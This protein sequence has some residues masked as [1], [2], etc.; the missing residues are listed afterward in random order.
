ML[1]IWENKYFSHYI[2]YIP[3]LQGIFLLFLSFIYN[4]YKGYFIFQMI[5][6]NVRKQKWLT[7]LTFHSNLLLDYVSALLIHSFMIQHH[8]VLMWAKPGI[9]LHLPVC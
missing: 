1:I 7:S 6:F 2:E 5:F 3:Q 9:A 4:R 8:V